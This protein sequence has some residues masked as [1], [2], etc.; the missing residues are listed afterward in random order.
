MTKQPPKYSLLHFLIFSLSIVTALSYLIIFINLNAQRIKESENGFNSIY[1]N[2]SEH[3]GHG[4]LNLK[5]IMTTH[6]NLENVSYRLM[7]ITPSGQPFIHTHRR[8]DQLESSFFTLPF[9]S[10]PEGVTKAYNTDQKELLGWAVLPDNY[11]LYVQIIHPPMPIDWTHPSYWLPILTALILMIWGFYLNL[12]HRLAWQYLIDYTNAFPTRL[13]EPYKPLHHKALASN[14]DFQ[15]QANSLNRINQQ[16][17]HLFRRNQTLKK[18]LNRITDYSPLPMLMI[19]RK[20][21][22]TYFNQRFEQVFMAVF[23]DEVSYHV[24]DFLMGKDKTTQQVLTNL[25][26]LR[27]SRTLNVASL[28]NNTDYLLHLFPWTGKQGQIQGFCAQLTNVDRLTTELKDIHIKLQQQADRLVEFDMLWSVLGH[29]LRTPLSGMI[30]LIDLMDTDNFSADQLE[31]Y[32]TLEQT[33]QTMLTMLNDMLDV[34]KMDAGKLQVVIERTDILTLCYQVADLMSSN[35]RNHHIELLVYFA[36]Q[37]PRYIDTDSGRIRQA[38]M[39]LLGNAIKFTHTGYVALLVSKLD[40][41]SD[42]L[43]QLANETNHMSEQKIQDDWLCLTVK[44]TGIGI[45]AEDKT[46]L[47]T[48]FSQANESIS[49]QF[50]GT[51]LGLAISNNFAQ[52]LGGFIH[53]TSVIGEGSEFSLYLPLKHMTYQPVYQF[54]ADLTGI[55]LIAF[56]SQQ[57]STDALNVLADYLGFACLVYTGVHDKNLTKIAKLNLDNF[58]TI[59]LVEEELYD[60]YDLAPVLTLPKLASAPKILLSMQPENGISPNRAEPYNAFLTKPLMVNHLI[61][62]LIKLSNINDEWSDNERRYTSKTQKLFNAFMTDLHQ[63]ADKTHPA[64]Q[65][66]SYAEDAPGDRDLEDSTSNLNAS[67]LLIHD[68]VPTDTD[69]SSKAID[70]KSKAEQLATEKGSLIL[71]AEDNAINQKVACKVLL[72]LGY[73]SVT[74]D[75]G[76]QVLAILKEQGDDIGLILMDCRMPILNGFETTK[77]LRAAKN[78]I[79][80]IALTAN[81]TDADREECLA[82]GMNGFLSK[83][84]KKDKLTSILERFMLY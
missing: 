29:E 63:P 82:A 17:H 73:R 56:T 32:T 48:H 68:R 44:D 13:N 70:P 40:R 36:P 67:L 66:S 50:G 37:C 71:V 6:R 57:L 31:T 3:I 30:G 38:L 65:G 47:F 58:T 55:C 76:E 81:D 52:M 27:V 9:W 16:L 26:E 84:I 83:P 20:G 10:Y 60:S 80:I 62:Q 22:I 43:R 64:I 61:K 35:A 72:Q 34:A 25:S 41:N 59:L 45:S 79:P 18:R 15:R 24:T 51:G 42:T 5:E 11:Q 49:R 39:N 46:K 1:H 74:A 8:E 23:Q 78:T 33:G 54:N 77:L 7:V 53:V 69:K 4:N 19:N 75:N 12:V 2:V 28:Q 21:S 14:Q